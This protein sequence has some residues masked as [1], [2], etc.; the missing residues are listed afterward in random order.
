QIVDE[1]AIC[2]QRLAAQGMVPIPAQGRKRK[3][4]IG[5]LEKSG[6]S[7]IETLEAYGRLQPARGPLEKSLAQAPGQNIGSG[8]GKVI[9]HFQINDI[10]N[11]IKGPSGGQGGGGQLPVQFPGKT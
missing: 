3:E 8:R 11:G 4:K 6:R 7:P 10:R 5:G 1:E 2:F 9:F